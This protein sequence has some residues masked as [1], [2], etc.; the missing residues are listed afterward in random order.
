MKTL[1]EYFIENQYLIEKYNCR[2]GFGVGM[3]TG[4][5]KCPMYKNVC[6]KGTY[7]PTSARNVRRF[8]ARQKGSAQKTKSFWE[9]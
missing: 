5:M 6:N 4:G 2:D 1:E 8:F 9:L 7:H 3:S